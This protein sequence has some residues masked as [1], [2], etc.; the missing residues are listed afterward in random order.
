M[1]RIVFTV[2]MLCLVSLLVASCAPAAAP[3][4]TPTK[5]VAP[6]PTKPA[7]TPTKAP[8]ATPTKVAVKPVEL[9]IAES[10]SMGW[11]QIPIA[12]A[13]ELWA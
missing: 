11:A 8:E 6:T 12:D 1:K 7:P 4:P 2:S 3:T 9:T 10:P 13:K 5:V